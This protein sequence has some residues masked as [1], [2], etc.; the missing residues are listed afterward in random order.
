MSS[1]PLEIKKF[2]PLLSFVGVSVLG[3]GLFRG[4]SMGGRLIYAIS[5]GGA[6]YLSSGVLG[7]T[8]FL[9]RTKAFS[10]LPLSIALDRALT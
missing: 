9:N 1:S 7:L 6:S 3:H 10:S 8:P 5:A 4:S 2:L